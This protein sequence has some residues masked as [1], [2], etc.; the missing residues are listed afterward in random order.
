MA[1]LGTMVMG[2]GGDD[3][4]FQRAA[5]RVQ[6]AAKELSDDFK[7]QAESINL[8]IQSAQKLGQA[9]DPAKLDAMRKKMEA[10]NAAAAQLTPSLKDSGDELEKFAIRVGR[11]SGVAIAAE[12]IRNMAKAA[13]EFQVQIAQGKAEVTDL[14]EAVAKKLPFGVGKLV[15]AGRDI[16]GL[17]T[18]DTA[19]IAKSDAD[20]KAAE[21]KIDLQTKL[22]D[23]TRK[24][25]REFEDANR[26]LNFDITKSAF[27][28]SASKIIEGGVRGGEDR[29]RAR[30]DTQGLLDEA[31]KQ[32]IAL[33]A[34]LDELK[35]R[36]TETHATDP[37]EDV[38]P[39]FSDRDV[40]AK[41]QQIDKLSDKIRDYLDQLDK[42]NALLNSDTGKGGR[43]TFTALANLVGGEVVKAFDTAVASLKRYIQFMPQMTSETSRAVA[44]AGGKFLE[45]R[46]QLNA[47]QTDFGK[48]L[49]SQKTLDQLNFNAINKTAGA[50]FWKSAGESIADGFSQFQAI[51]DP[52]IGG[53]ISD[54]REKMSNILR[55]FGI[56]PNFPKEPKPD[57]PI[58]FKDVPPFRA[59]LVGLEQLGKSI[60]E[61]AGSDSGQTAEGIKKAVEASLVEQR[62]QTELLKKLKGPIG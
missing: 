17:I 57:K 2:F 35:R 15:E 4:D 41:Q 33:V 62:R 59:S 23:A 56:G 25:R 36:P 12:G 38:L 43:P 1:E 47:F 45:L 42:L 18:G 5:S 20:V 31:N 44:Q 54:L 53:V 32:K 22:V 3:A 28:N 8:A 29:L 40:A 50:D 60:Q 21:K 16:H 7:R 51:V 61:G 6:R 58:E 9:L 49:I 10:L 39:T 26:V 13:L 55:T 19:A 48:G 46:T 11:I 52:K 14:I 27:F 30:A 24:A 34:D 37:G